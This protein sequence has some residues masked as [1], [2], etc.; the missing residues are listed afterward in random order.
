MEGM[1]EVMEAT[2]GMVAM[3]EAM[4]VMADMVVM[5]EEDT[6]AMADTDE[7]MV[8]M[9]GANNLRLIIPIIYYQLKGFSTLSCISIQI[10][11]VLCRYGE[12]VIFEI[13]FNFE[14]K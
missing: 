4:E 12:F 9:D 2:A 11:F 6:V 14:F 5:A 1:V 8:A 10:F 7:A 13:E 3:E